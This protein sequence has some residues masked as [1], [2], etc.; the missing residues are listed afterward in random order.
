LV[1]EEVL[2]QNPIASPQQLVEALA[3]EI[4]NPQKAREFRKSVETD[5]EF[6]PKPAAIPQL[7]P[8][9][10][11][12][13]QQELARCIG[14]MASCILDETLAKHPEM[15]PLQLVDALATEI[16]NPKKVQEFKKRVETELEFQPKPLKKVSRFNA[17]F[18]KRGE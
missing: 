16:P 5:P 4:P 6:Q 3:A 1:L 15:T 2:E 17:A 9:F 10:I 11:K 18:L 13:C 14:P 12:R 8:A 7:N